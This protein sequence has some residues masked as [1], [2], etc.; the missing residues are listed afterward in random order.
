MIAAAVA[1]AHLGYQG[2]QNLVGG[3]QR[4]FI[5]DASVQA[6]DL[7]GWLEPIDGRRGQPAVHPAG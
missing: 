4:D 5:K 2:A 6:T 7:T 3:L 1:L